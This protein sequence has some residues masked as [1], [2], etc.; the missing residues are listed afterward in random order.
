MSELGKLWGAV[1]RGYI[2]GLSLPHPFSFPLLFFSGDLCRLLSHDIKQN[3][4]GKSSGWEKKTTK[5][6]TS[7]QYL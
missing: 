6:T 2:P 3:K 1:V 4:E 5:P 7:V